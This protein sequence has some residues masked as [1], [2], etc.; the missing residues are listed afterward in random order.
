MKKWLLLLFI[1]I[2]GGVLYWNNVSTKTSSVEK[3][4]KIAN[5]QGQKK[6]ETEKKYVEF[7]EEM[8]ND[9]IVSTEFKT[10]DRKLSIKIHNNSKLTRNEIEFVMDELLIGYEGITAILPELELPSETLD[11]IIYDSDNASH[12]AFFDSIHIIRSDEFYGE[13][14]IHELSHF[15][16]NDYAIERDYFFE[17]GFASYLQEEYGSLKSYV[18]AP[19]HNVMKYFISHNR[20]IDLNDLM[21]NDNAHKIVKNLQ[22][23]SEEQFYYKRWLGYVQAHS[24]IAFLIEHY[25]ID[26][27][28]QIHFS[29]EQT[30]NLVKVYTKNLDELEQE[31]LDYMSSETFELTTKQKGLF[32]Y[33]YVLSIIETLDY[34]EE[35]D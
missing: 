10:K 5:L 3:Q 26:L 32:N 15:L 23:E 19:N 22:L 31:W 14:I 33:D 34:F 35:V 9:Y 16:L 17:E 18:G 4:E 27:Y 12:R 28:K 20:V 30:E 6:S 7:V 2:I 8:E 13:A 21:I 29:N 11:V 25:G 1:T 24:F